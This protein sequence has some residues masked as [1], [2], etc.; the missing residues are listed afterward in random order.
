MEK[1]RLIDLIGVLSERELIQ[2]ILDHWTHWAEEEFFANG[3][4][5]SLDQRYIGTRKTFINALMEA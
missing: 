5:I 2:F 4:N 1:K 3:D